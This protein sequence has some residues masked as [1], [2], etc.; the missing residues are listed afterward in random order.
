VRLMPGCWAMAALA[1]AA[2]DSPSRIF[3]IMC[4]LPV[5]EV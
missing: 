2:M 4:F 3:L 5:G 1:I